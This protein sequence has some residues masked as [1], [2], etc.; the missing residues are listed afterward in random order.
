MN[1]SDRRSLCANSSDLEAKSA[2]RL[3]T[4]TELR[5]LAE[6]FISDKDKLEEKIEEVQ[7]LRVPEDSKK[8]LIE[9]IQQEISNLRERY[10]KQV[11]SVSAKAQRELEGLTES[12][13]ETADEFEEEEESLN[14]VKFETETDVSAAAD[15][16]EANKTHYLEMKTKYVE[17]LEK[18]IQE[19]EEY[20]RQIYSTGRSR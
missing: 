20:R 11:D 8:K 5:S 3:E 1:I 10:D 12:M 7:K 9:N 18:S 19:S 2:I 17:E 4:I 14:E 15:E 13:Q 6:N 16:A